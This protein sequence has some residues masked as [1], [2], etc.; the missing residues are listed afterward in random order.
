MAWRAWP[1]GPH[2]HGQEHGARQ[3]AARAA[4]LGEV[5]LLLAS[6]GVR[7]RR[8]GRGGKLGPRPLLEGSQC[9]VAAA[10]GAGA[11]AAAGATH[12][13]VLVVGAAPAVGQLGALALPELQEQHGPQR[14]ERAEEDGALVVE[15]PAGLRGAG[16]QAGAGSLGL[17]CGAQGTGGQRVAPRDPGGLDEIQDFGGVLEVVQ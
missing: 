4:S 8:G 1:A 11:A 14:H 16:L 13:D 2:H 7:G 15:E 9:S 12:L 3:H 10:A 6:D 5:G 17:R